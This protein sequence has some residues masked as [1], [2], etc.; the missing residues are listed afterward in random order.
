MSKSRIFL[1]LVCVLSVAACKTME[2]VIGDLDSL[3]LAPVSL[4]GEP[5]PE[6]LGYNTLCPQVKVVE[7][8]GTYSEFSDS[9]STDR[10]DLVSEVK[11]A[12]VKSACNTDTKNVTMDLKMSFQGTLGPEG[13]SMSSSEPFFSYPFFVAVTDGRGKILAKE[14]FSAN[15]NYAGGTQTQTYTEN[16]R[17]ILPIDPRDRGERFKI[18]LGFQ[19]G[20]DQLDYN[21]Q[22]IK[23]QKKRAKERAKAQARAIKDTPQ[24]EPAD[25]SG[26]SP[27]PQVEKPKPHAGFQYDP[28]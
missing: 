18:L 5:A 16:M 15:M 12:R 2:G 1:C 9:G 24:K 8:L 21:R 25:S 19:L 7:E 28:F 4:D 3:D 27:V 20:A 17:Q 14:I 11:I 26:A 23:I 22:Q 13:R 6:D 10:E